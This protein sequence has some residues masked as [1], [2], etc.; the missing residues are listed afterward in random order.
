MRADRD[1]TPAVRLALDLQR[2][3]LT[4]RDAG[5]P[6]RDFAVAQLRRAGTAYGRGWSIAFHGAALAM[7]AADLSPLANRLAWWAVAVLDGRTW[8]KCTPADLARL[9]GVHRSS[10]ARALAELV[11]FGWI[12]RSGDDPTALRLS[13]WA[14]WQGTAQAFQ[15]ERRQRPAEIEAG[16]AH[17]APAQL[18]AAWRREMAHLAA[19][20]ARPARR[21]RRASAGIKE[22][23][24]TPITASEMDAII[25]DVVAG[26]ASRVAVLN[27]ILDRMAAERGVRLKR[28]G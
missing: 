16:L 6:D 23:A 15:K 26:P 2:R 7:A 24:A 22:T 25:A 1:A 28:Q 9:F 5:Q 19:S 20:G 27:A 8:T 21:R 11:K 12:I 3:T 18:L 4:V 14:G 10:A 17:E 13:L